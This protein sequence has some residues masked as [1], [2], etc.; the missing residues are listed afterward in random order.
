MRFPAPALLCLLR[1]GDL[2]RREIPVIRDNPGLAGC[3][4]VCAAFGVGEFAAN[5]IAIGDSVFVG[6]V[7][8]LQNAEL[9]P[10][11]FS[12]VVWSSGANK[13]VVLKPGTA[14]FDVA[15]GAQQNNRDE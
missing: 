2:F 10:G 4:C 6:V 12:D 1:G 15:G 11:E 9:A 3:R 5:Q 8:G 14:G 7:A 13:D